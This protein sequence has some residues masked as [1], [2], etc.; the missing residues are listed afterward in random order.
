MSFLIGSFAG[1]VASVITSPLD[2]IKTRMQTQTPTSL[3]RY[4]GVLHGLLEVTR[5][6]GLWALRIEARLLVR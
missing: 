1:S 3:T 4:T 6:E 5:H 2:I